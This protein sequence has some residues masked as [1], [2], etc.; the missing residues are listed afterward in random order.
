MIGIC[1]KLK[2]ERGCLVGCEKTTGLV[3]LLEWPVVF[4]VSFDEYG[5]YRLLHGS[6]DDIWIVLGGS[7]RVYFVS[8]E[9]KRLL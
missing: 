7:V 5:N 3:L 2:E 6:I 4:R 8:T 9:N 1:E